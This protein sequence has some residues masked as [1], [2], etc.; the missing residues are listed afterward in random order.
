MRT[1]PG[2]TKAF[3][4]AATL[5]GVALLGGLAGSVSARD[6]REWGRSRPPA[7]SDLSSPR[8]AI[9]DFDGDQQPD[10]A[11][12]QVDPDGQRVTQYSI[13][14][15]LSFGK[16]SFIGLTAPLGGLQLS[17]KD[18]NGDRTLD[19]VVTRVLDAHLVAVFV[20]DGH[21]QFSLAAEGAFPELK[22]LGGC[23]INTS[24]D[25]SSNQTSILQS[26]CPS[27]DEG[28][29]ATGID[30]LGAS[31]SLLFRVRQIATRWNA[32]ASRGRSP[33]SSRPRP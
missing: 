6:L 15:Q 18:V 25:L 4:L 27:G 3:G 22:T 19:L 8:F 17:A 7:G 9:G 10:L 13:Q 11:T 14:L 21:G 20:N 12:V 32:G 30:S 28:Q 1:H 26:R 23:G 24:A 16:K 33:P 29:D 31:E 2:M 5:V